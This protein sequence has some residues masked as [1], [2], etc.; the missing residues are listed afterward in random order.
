MG[1][2]PIAFF[3]HCR[4]LVTG[5]PL[6]PRGVST[7]TQSLVN[8]D[9]VCW[10]APASLIEFLVASPMSWREGWIDKKA[11]VVLPDQFFNPSLPSKD[12]LD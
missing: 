10:P 1:D 4:L 11:L 7:P 6:G 5:T 12:P 3:H 2:M 8:L 9:D